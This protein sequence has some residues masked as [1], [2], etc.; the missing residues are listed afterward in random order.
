MLILALYFLAAFGIAFIVGQ[1]KISHPFRVL[2]GGHQ[3]TDE[4]GDSY[5]PCM[6]LIPYVGPFLVTLV[7]CPGCLGFWIGLASSNVIWT[8]A[9]LPDVH[10]L[11]K[12]AIFSQATAGSNFILSRICR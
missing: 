6:P 9:A 12:L 11:V 1:S 2:L 3:H 4:N 10:A 8:L 7:E 5:G